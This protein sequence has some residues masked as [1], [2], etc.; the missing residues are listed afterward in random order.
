M[1][2]INI[3]IIFIGLNDQCIDLQCDRGFGCDKSSMDVVV[4]VAFLIDELLSMLLRAA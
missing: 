3:T 2:T 1:I 4:H